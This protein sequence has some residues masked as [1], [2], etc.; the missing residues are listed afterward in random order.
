MHAAT[1]RAALSL[2]AWNL[3]TLSKSRKNLRRNVLAFEREPDSSESGWNLS[4]GVDTSYQHEALVGVAVAE[5][6]LPSDAEPRLELER[7]AEPFAKPSRVGALPSS[8]TFHMCNND[9]C[10][11]FCGPSDRSLTRGSYSGHSSAAYA[12]YLNHRSSL[13]LRRSGNSSLRRPNNRNRKPYYQFIL[14]LT[15]LENSSTFQLFCRL[16]T[17]SLLGLFYVEWL[18]WKDSSCKT[19]LSLKRRSKGC[20]K[21]SERAVTVIVFERWVLSNT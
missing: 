13:T 5:L 10:N 19:N 16:F 17:S 15:A 1:G 11:I 21:M 7:D 20:E 6:L 18:R 3:V 8:D 4:A 14:F 9:T 2:W 12:D